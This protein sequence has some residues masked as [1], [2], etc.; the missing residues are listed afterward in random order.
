MAPMIGVNTRRLLRCVSGRF[1]RSTSTYVGMSTRVDELADREVLSVG[2]RRRL[3][4]VFT[5][6]DC[7][8]RFAEPV[9][10]HLPPVLRRRLTRLQARQVELL[11]IEVMPDAID[12]NVEINQLLALAA[13]YHRHNPPPTSALFPVRTFSLT[14]TSSVTRRVNLFSPSGPPPTSVRVHPRQSTPAAQSPRR[15]L[16]TDLHDGQQSESPQLVHPRLRHVQDRCRL[17]NG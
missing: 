17:R 8:V 11:R 15:G 10:L 12:P 5:T 3:P 4:G 7:G 9:A 1:N 16:T 6:L 2:L 14:Y 13:C